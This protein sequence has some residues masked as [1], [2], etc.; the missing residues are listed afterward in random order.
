VHKPSPEMSALLW[1]T[2]QAS[3]GVVLVKLAET[4][5]ELQIPLEGQILRVN[6]QQPTHWPTREQD[7]VHGIQRMQQRDS[8]LSHLE[9]AVSAFHN[10]LDEFPRER[11]PAVWA[12]IQ[13]D[14]ALGLIRLGEQ[15]ERGHL[16]DALC[17]VNLAL[18][19]WTYEHFPWDW[20]RVQSTL[21]WIFIRLGERQEGPAISYF[22][23]AVEACQKASQVQTRD[24]SPLAWAKNENYRG[25]ALYRIGEAQNNLASLNE[26]ASAYSSALEVFRSLSMNSEAVENNLHLVQ[27]KIQELS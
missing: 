3:L 10:S 15:G 9:A 23:S 8:A 16:L 14:F 20:A 4:E 2:V 13:H 24:N 22:E 6:P 1:A 17:R 5:I 19:V 26:A 7:L 27:V 25:I 18:E 21:S 12:S 11:F